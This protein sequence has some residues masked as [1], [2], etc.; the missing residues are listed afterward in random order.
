M[1]HFYVYITTNPGKTVLY[2][3]VTSD[4]RRR[5]IEHYNNRG[6]YNTFTG[7]YYC[8]RLIYLE[9]FNNAR[10][11]IYREKEIKNMSR[12]KKE[13]LIALKNPNWYFMDVFSSQ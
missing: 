11:A 5:M 4:L 3:G 1:K 10:N 13:K 6:N 12:S 9:V 2:V 8:Y 7:K